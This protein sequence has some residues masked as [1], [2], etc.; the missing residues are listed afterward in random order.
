MMPDL[1]GMPHVDI[2]ASIWV[3]YYCI[4]YQGC[5]FPTKNTPPP[6]YQSYQRRL[7][8]CCLRSLPVWRKQATGTITDF[9]A[10][11]FIVSQW[12]SLVSSYHAP[13]FFLSCSR[14]SVQLT[15]FAVQDIS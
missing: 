13:S 15:C 9:L 4:L 6:D 8:I 7:Y 11:L 10:A 1:V 5:W 2:D 3:I 14:G 12:L